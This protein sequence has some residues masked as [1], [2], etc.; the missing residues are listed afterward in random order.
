M[1][2]AE[3]VPVVRHECVAG[4]RRRP[5]VRAVFGVA[6]I[7][8]AVFA[9]H[10]LF[11]CA[12]S[13][14]GAATPVSAAAPANAAAPL[15]AETPG[16]TSA[17]AALGRKLFFDPVLSASGELACATCHDPRYAYGPPPGRAI[18]LGGRDGAASGTRAVPALRYARSAPP[19]SLQHR[20]VDGDLGP[21][22]GFT[23]DGRA[24]SIAEQAQLPLFAANEMA[25]A[26]AAEVV[27]RLRHSAY[28]GDFRSLFGS[29]VFDNP[30]RAVDSLLQALDAFQRVPGEFAPFT[31]RYDAYLRGEIELT[32]QEERGVEIFKDPQKGNC[33]SCHTVTSQGGQ[34]PT[35][36]D[37]DYANVG[38]PRNA[39]IPANADPAY[40]DRG[41]CGPLRQDIAAKPEYCGLF[42][43]PSLRNVAIRDAFFHNGVFDSLRRVLEFY[44]E[45]DLYPEKYYSRNPN[46]TV[47]KY[48]DMPPGQADNVDHDAPLD[49]KPGAA[50]ALD[51]ADIDDLMAFLQTLN[52][53]DV[54]R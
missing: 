11:A 42:R 40:F 14:A 5:R 25:N 2:F 22:G 33:A 50:P 36:S 43:A 29:S 35:F 39:R 16:S 34:P 51:A 37:Y 18:A 46:G 32:D 15:S 3:S 45:R 30:A 44:V 20:F 54:V 6:R 41:L 26:S 23:W 48:D 38:V 49:R 53:A 13:P 27:G 52:D 10:V 28:A 31:S 19:F 9:A 4:R 8:A 7:A 47:H 21:M 1:G 24:G 12:V 17:L